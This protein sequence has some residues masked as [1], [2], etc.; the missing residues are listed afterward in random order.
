[1]GSF[2][3]SMIMG[4]FFNFFVRLCWR[5]YYGYIISPGSSE[6]NN[7]F[8][9]FVH[10]HNRHGNISCHIWLMLSCIKHNASTYGFWQFSLDWSHCFCSAR[11]TAIINLDWNQCINVPIDIAI[12]I[13]I[14][15][16][17]WVQVIPGITLINLQLFTS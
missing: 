6:L 7:I 12:Y 1:M 9:F 3:K 11:S 2:V 15:I 16:Y 13:Y 14:Y 10:G 17:K 4:L 8:I 5:K